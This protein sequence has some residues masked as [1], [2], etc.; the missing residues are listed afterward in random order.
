MRIEITKGEIDAVVAL[1]SNAPLSEAALET[2]ERLSASPKRLMALNALLEERERLLRPAT[3]EAPSEPAP[4][5]KR[6]TYPTLKVFQRNPKIKDPKINE[7][8]SNEAEIKLP[9]SREKAPRSTNAQEPPASKAPKLPK[10]PSPKPAPRAAA[11]N[12]PAPKKAPATLEVVSP[13]REEISEPAAREKTSRS[14]EPL[15]EEKIVAAAQAFMQQKKLFPFAQTPGA[16]PGLP[17][18][19]WRSIDQAAR[20]GLR[21]LVGGSTLQEIIAPLWLQPKQPK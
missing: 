7:P 14:P 11:N 2:L 16:I 20:L 15:S 12:R 4:K 21:G 19:T 17:G 18:D 9:G 6:I 13:P 5:P 10:P 1:R 8:K 3:P